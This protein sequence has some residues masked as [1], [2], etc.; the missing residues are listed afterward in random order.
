MLV[1]V[2]LLALLPV[3]MCLWAILLVGVG[4][5]RSVSQMP[6]EFQLA[7]RLAVDTKYEGPPWTVVPAAIIFLAFFNLPVPFAIFGPYGLEGPLA[8]VT[9]VLAQLGWLLR[10]RKAIGEANPQ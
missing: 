6:W 3:T 1:A 9:Y 8:A 7:A 4:A 5:V 2:F 10:L